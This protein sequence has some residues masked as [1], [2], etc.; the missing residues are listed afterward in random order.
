MFGQSWLF[1]VFLSTSVTPPPPPG[2]VMFLSI[3]HQAGVHPSPHPEQLEGSPEAEPPFS[4]KK[5]I[6]PADEAPS[7]Y[8]LT[9]HRKNWPCA[10]TYDWGGAESRGKFRQMAGPALRIGISWYGVGWRVCIPNKFPGE[11]NSAGPMSTL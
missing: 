5:M 9:S 2:H 4:K 6:S 11:A 7:R 1:S 3:Q 8:P 10:H